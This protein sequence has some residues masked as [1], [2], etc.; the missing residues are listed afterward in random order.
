[1]AQKILVRHAQSYAN[2]LTR[3]AFGVGGAELTEQGH[4]QSKIL[5]ATFDARSI[6]KKQYVAVSELVRAQQT[7]ASAGF[8]AQTVRPVLNE[9]QTEQSPLEVTR[10]AANGILP[11]EA[12]DRAEELLRNPP[13]ETIWF[14]HGLV[15]AGMRDV[16]GITAPRLVPEFCEITE[17]E[18]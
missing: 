16:L 3:L 4:E 6:D 9:L 12:Y 15:I 1:M 8:I 2:R 13:P 10:N 14:T 11:K 18:L 5:G 7:A 17:I